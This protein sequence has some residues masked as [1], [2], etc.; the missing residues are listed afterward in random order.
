MRLT[1]NRSVFGVA[2]ASL[3][4][5]S[6]L[7]AVAQKSTDSTV[8]LREIE[9]MDADLLAKT[10]QTCAVGEMANIKARIDTDEIDRKYGA[11]FPAVEVYCLKAIYVSREQKKL[12]DLY[13]NLALQA[14]GYHIDFNFADMS[15]KLQNNEVGRTILAILSAA[16]SGAGSYTSITG[17]PHDL[18][19]PLAFDAGMTW[20]S[21]TPSAAAPMALTMAE[22]TAA[23]RQC[24][25]P[26]VTTITLQGT[27]M[28]A[29][30]AGLIVGAW[31]AKQ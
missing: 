22:A 4:A 14:Q 26:G 27:A 7:P 30:K 20:A 1:C 6:A 16:K 18:P 2:V 24:Y 5:A 9:L 29:T 17:K 28:P 12:N 11:P 21:T 8:Y 31:L 3:L 19:C 23:I 13:I 15:G 10:R 25:A